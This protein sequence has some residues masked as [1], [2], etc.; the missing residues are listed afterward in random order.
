[1]IKKALGN[2]PHFITSI[3]KDASS[4]YGFNSKLTMSLAQKLYEA[5]M[6]T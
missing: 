2:I 3:T 1:M 4:K 5:G 6:I